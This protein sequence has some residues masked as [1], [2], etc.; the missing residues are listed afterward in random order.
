ML[1]CSACAPL[2]AQ[3]D[4]GAILPLTE[5]VRVAVIGDYGTG[6]EGET[7]VVHALAEEHRIK[8]FQLGLTLGDNFYYCGVK[9][10]NDKIWDTVWASYFDPLKIPFYATYG[11]HDYG[12]GGGPVCFGT[13]TNPKAEI[14]Y[15]ARS[16]TWRMPAAYYRFTAGPVEFLALDT[17]KWGPSEREWVSRWL[18]RSPKGIQWR[19]VYGHRPIYSSG[20]HRGSVALQ[21]Q[22]LPLLKKAKVDVYLSGHDHDMEHLEAG[23]IQFFVAGGGGA[24]TYGVANRDPHSIFAMQEHGFLELEADAETL[25][26]RLVSS[27]GEVLGKPFVKTK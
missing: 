9:S 15:T 21:R 4:V 17:E 6:G 7:E 19:V 20:K 12:R 2:H 5:P 1:L 11:N 27:K 3:K 25:S 26:V 14:A 24:S 23:G 13:R 18:A 22:L 16:E 8:P 10:V